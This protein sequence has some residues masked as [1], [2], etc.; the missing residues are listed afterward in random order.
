MFSG[1][2]DRKKL[3]K[4]VYKR[5][6][7]ALTQ[8]LLDFFTASATGSDLISRSHLIETSKFLLTDFNS[9]YFRWVYHTFGS[10][11]LEFELNYFAE[12]DKKSNVLL[13]V[14]SE[15]DFWADILVLCSSL[16]KS[17]YD[18]GFWR[19]ELKDL[20]VFLKTRYKKNNSGFNKPS[21]VSDNNFLI[22]YDAFLSNTVNN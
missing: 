6:F 1:K 7:D 16:D 12:K 20:V 5:K 13:T 17:N 19:V 18:L 10:S 21:S 22:H 2:L 3:F 14:V 8:V 11:K 4:F 9:A 15:S